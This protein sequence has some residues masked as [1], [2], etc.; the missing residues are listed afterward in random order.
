[1][2]RS[3][4]QASP[5]RP[6]RWRGPLVVGLCFALGYGITQRLIDLGLPSLV[7]LGHGFDMRPFPGT[8]LESL[9][10][11]FGGGR[12]GQQIR[13]DLDAV[14]LERQRRE[15]EQDA[16]RKAEQSRKSQEPPLEIE[17]PQE[18]EQERPVATDSAQPQPA[19]KPAPAPATAPAPAQPPPPSAARSRS[20]GGLL[21]AP[22]PPPLPPPEVP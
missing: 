21:E 1:M 19:P 8:S 12:E 17:P 9:R 13:G 14:E 5:A 4:A 18:Q 15:A 10:Q 6:P 11:R 16:A 22:A 3:Q 2:A 7:Q 20:S